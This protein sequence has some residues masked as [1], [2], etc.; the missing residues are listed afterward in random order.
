[1]A[2]KMPW[3][4]YSEEGPWGEY[5]KPEQPKPEPQEPPTFGEALMPRT[6]KKPGVVSA[7]LDIAS[8][9]FRGA[10]TGVGSLAQLLA[11]MQ[12]GD[13]SGVN[14]LERLAQT[15]GKEGQPWY[16]NIGEEILR[17]P[18]NVLGGI[19][20]ITKASKAVKIAKPI[21]EGLVSGGMHLAD[22]SVQGEDL[23]GGDVAVQLV[24]EAGVPAL[25]SGL[26]KLGRRGAAA[27]TKWNVRQPAMA[28]KTEPN[29][30]ET[31]DIITGKK[32]VV[33]E[34]EVIAPSFKGEIDRPEFEFTT[35]K[36]VDQSSAGGP[37]GGTTLKG[38]VEDINKAIKKLEEPKA[39][40]LKQADQGAFAEKLYMDY[41][42]QPEVYNAMSPNDPIRAA[43]DQNYATGY[44]KLEDVF[45][46]ASEKLE[47]NPKLTGD[48]EKVRAE[49]NRAF[50]NYIG[51]YPEEL[52]PSELDRLKKSVGEYGSWASSGG[53]TIV[54]PDASIKEA[55]YNTLYDVSKT[56]LE[57][58][59]GHT[60]TVWSK[61]IQ[62][63]LGL[64]L[65]EESPQKITETFKKINN[66][67][68]ELLTARKFI[69]KGAQ[70]PI[71]PLSP[72]DLLLGTTGGSAG[73]LM[74][75]GKG[76]ITGLVPAATSMAMRYQP[77]NKAIYELSDLMKNLGMNQVSGQLTRD[78]VS[79]MLSPDAV[80]RRLNNE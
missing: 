56:K 20:N 44:T 13:Y 70:K 15:G 23:S 62:K 46:E 53:R 10:V 29:I 16:Q 18:A 54:D 32:K 17:D 47:A 51:E 49:L 52:L 12:T 65:G 11:A 77:T 40:L 45:S 42:R 78:A 36:V 76:G 64:N 60:T 9:P 26:G 69:E 71:Q 25:L 58:R 37:M 28:A 35:G 79:S 43:L 7:G 14:S 1:M 68:H 31:M 72:F 50:N 2:E 30:L 80:Q 4:E 5:A 38:T 24:S 67:E 8:L 63:D 61:S 75:G 59:I 3:E 55:V 21:V 74:G 19:G 57:N 6:T 48:R 27:K 41:F 39:L 34:L 22:R 66:Q 33:P 73:A